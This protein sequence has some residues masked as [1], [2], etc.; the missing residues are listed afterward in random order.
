M[1]GSADIAF[2]IG[3]SFII[4]AG[5]LIILIPVMDHFYTEQ[6]KPGGKKPENIQKECLHVYCM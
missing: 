1:S 2:Y 4:V 3:G 6:T 5:L